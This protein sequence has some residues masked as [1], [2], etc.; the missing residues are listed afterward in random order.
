MDEWE[1]HYVIRFLEYHEDQHYWD[2]TEET[3]DAFSITEFDK[4]WTCFKDCIDELFERRWQEPEYLQ[5]IVEYECDF[6]VVAEF[7]YRWED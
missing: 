3:V 5:L 2:V 4:A 1:D 7:K 6:Y